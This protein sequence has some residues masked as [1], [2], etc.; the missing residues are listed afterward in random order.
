M[1][2]SI[3]LA[4]DDEQ[5]AE[6]IL[7][8]LQQHGVAHLVALVRDGKEA[9]DYLHR[10]GDYAARPPGN[11]NL[12]LLDLA[13]P[14]MDGLEL[15]KILKADAQLRVIPV[16]VLSTSRQQRDLVECY[17]LGVNAYVI[18]PVD[19]KEFVD[20]VAQLGVFWTAVNVPPPPPSE[21]GEDGLTERLAEDLHILHL[22]DDP[23]AGTLVTTTLKAAGISCRIE[24]VAN[25]RDFV[26]ALDA[27]GIELVLANSSVAFFEGLEALALV[28]ARWP[29][30]PFILVADSLQAELAM[31]ARQFEVTDYVFKKHLSRLAPAVRRAMLEVESRAARASLETKFIEA[32]KM[33]VVGQLAGG[34]AHD[35]NNILAVVLGFS[36]LL[37]M[38]LEPDSPLRGYTEEMRLAAELGAGLTK[39]LLIFSQK[40]TVK[41]VILDLNE[42]VLGLDQLLRR[43]IK[44]NIDLTFVA[45][46][47]LGNIEADPGYVAQLLMNLA[48][49]ARDAMPEGGRLTIETS[50]G[51]HPAGLRGPFVILTVSDTGC[52]LSEEVKRRLFEPF[53]TTKAQG[54]GT[55]LGLATCQTILHQCQATITVDS[56]LGEGTSFV[57]YFPQ[58]GDAPSPTPPT[59]LVKG[60][61]AGTETL[62]VVEDDGALRS[63]AQ[64]ALSKQG[65]EVLA[66]ANGREAL[67]VAKDWRGAPIQLVVTD[68]VMPR[69]GGKVMAEW[70]QVSHPELKFLFTSGYTEE[71]VAQEGLSEPGTAFLPKPYTPATLTQKVRELLDATS[72]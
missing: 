67:Q 21:A 46:Q 63:L 47:D 70:L 20:A 15:L 26:S 25:R 1:N 51:S 12:V 10:R 16:V 19:F 23:S 5:D 72:G 38:E 55:G 28:R 13:M 7:A 27:G 24:R 11:P 58:V 6:L 64:N 45:G 65:Y 17:R 68:L 29:K 9:L 4:E 32:Q 56:E 54:K 39:Q 50:N 44:E 61:S 22:E 52:G 62:L 53:F 30:L 40:Q 42:V 69:M 33:D 8:A 2:K 59:G 3:L 31:D 41:P 60:A 71:A 18:K 34:V 57:M 43:L 66:A 36:E 14:Q 37:E 35:F 48:V 49:N